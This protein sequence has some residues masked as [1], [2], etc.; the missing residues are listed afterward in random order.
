V[1]DLNQQNR[2]QNAGHAPKGA[3][4]A[5]NWRGHS[6]KLRILEAMQ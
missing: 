3:H 4:S 6:S 5:V 2:R 1:I